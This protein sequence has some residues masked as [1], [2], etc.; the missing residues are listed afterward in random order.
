MSDDTAQRYLRDNFISGDRLA[1]V[2]KNHQTGHTIQ[3]VALVDKI[4]EDSYQAW[5]RHKNASRYEVYVSMNAL[6]AEA[7]GRT[8]DDVAVVRHIY[9]DFDEGGTAAV[10]RLLNREDVPEPNYLVNTSPDKWQV[11]WKAEG[12][13]KE[14]AEALQR[15]LV[16]ETGADPAAVDTSRVLRL[17]GYRNH[18][19]ASHPYVR[20]EARGNSVY[21]PEH[22][23]VSAREAPAAEIRTRVAGSESAGTQTSRYGGSQSEH[24]WAYA[25]RALAR[26]EPPEQ[27][28]ANIARFRAGEKHDTNSYAQRTVAKA[29][30]GMSGVL[31]GPEEESTPDR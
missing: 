26:G 12:F 14:Q 5:L 4:V 2:L 28:A 10:R 29:S 27:I 18:K 6:H 1:I 16:R 25:K 23:A 24:D 17:P 15:Q 20:V 9:L 30:I 19:Y 22:F 3:R 21:G 8:K 7:R 11:V 13:A 31:H